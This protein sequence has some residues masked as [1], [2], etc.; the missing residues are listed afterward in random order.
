MASVMNSMAILRC[1]FYGFYAM[2]LTSQARSIDVAWPFVARA[3]CTIRSC[4]T[5]VKVIAGREVTTIEGL[6]TD[7]NHPV[8]KAWLENNVPQC[9]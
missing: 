7:D 8:Q 2:S 6:S 4:S 9:G 5:P 1:L 3:L